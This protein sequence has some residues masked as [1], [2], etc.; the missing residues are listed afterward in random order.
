MLDFPALGAFTKYKELSVHSTRSCTMGQAGSVPGQSVSLLAA[1]ELRRKWI[2]RMKR[3]SRMAVTDS[4]Y[5]E[6]AG[7]KKKKKDSSLGRKRTGNLS[8]KCLVWTLARSGAAGTRT[9]L[10]AEEDSSARRIPAS[11]QDDTSTD[12]SLDCDATTASKMT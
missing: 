1:A 3:S 10:I 2:L 5:P 9:I 12:G 4:G 11:W 7:G 8:K 6:E